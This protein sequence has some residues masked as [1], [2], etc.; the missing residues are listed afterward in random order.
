VAEQDIAVPDTV[1]EAKKN[2]VLERARELFW[3]AG[4]IEDQGGEQ[5]E[6]DQ[7]RRTAM[8]MLT[9]YQIDAALAQ[10]GKVTVD[11]VVTREIAIKP[12]YAD[13]MATLAGAVATHFSGQI[14]IYGTGGT[15]RV[16]RDENGKPVKDEEGRTQYEWAATYG[17]GARVVMYGFAEDLDLAEMLYTSLLM[18]ATG[19]MVKQRPPFLP[20]L[21]RYED[22]ATFRASW[23]RG[24]A[25]AVRWRLKEIRDARTRADEAASGT[26]GTALVL[27]DRS[28]LVRRRYEQENPDVGQIRLA[29]SGSGERDGWR[30]GQKADLGMTPRVDDTGRAELTG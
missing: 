1:P 17:K 13:V 5:G 29:T 3:K 28:A 6:A 20:R 25:R 15:T 11:Q 16:K 9:K 22:M 21:H 4:L 24:F 18:Q 8:R 12:P 14:I 23:L 27:A 2:Q 26:P 19:E 7:M 30:A 10:D